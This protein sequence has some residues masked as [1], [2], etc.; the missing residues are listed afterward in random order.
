MSRDVNFEEKI[1]GNI[2]Y[3]NASLSVYKRR[4]V[5]ISDASCINHR[6]KSWISIRCCIGQIIS[7]INNNNIVGGN[8]GDN[9]TRKSNC[10][11]I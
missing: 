5:D 6:R 2:G 9:S 1:F 4:S 8:K 3:F 10:K 11:D 7:I